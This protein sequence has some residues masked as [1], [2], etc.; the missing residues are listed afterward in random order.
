MEDSNMAKY[1]S[2]RRQT[3]RKCFS[4]PA[5]L[6]GICLMTV[7]TFLAIGLARAEASQTDGTW[8][9]ENLVVRIFDCQQ[10]VC[11]RIAWINEAAKRQSQCGQ[12][13]IWGLAPS[14]QNEWT[15]GAILDPNDG[16]TYRLSASYE[17]DGTLHARIFEGIPLLGKTKILSRV[18]IRNFEGR[19]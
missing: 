14:A 10:Q 7:A 6:C 11:G 2:R 3:S 15:G 17:P 9:V 5:A 18:D 13:I 12:T 16:K 4:R 19:C 8:R 1:A